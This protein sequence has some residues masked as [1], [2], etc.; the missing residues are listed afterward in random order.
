MDTGVMGGCTEV[1]CMETVDMVMEWVRKVGK[2]KHSQYDSVI[3][4]MCNYN[5]F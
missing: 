4:L 5:M 3:T 2:H 1:G